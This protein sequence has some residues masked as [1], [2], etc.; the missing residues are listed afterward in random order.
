MKDFARRGAASVQASEASERFADAVAEVERAEEELAAWTRGEL[1]S[2]LG[3]DVFLA[4]FRERQRVLDETRQTL[5][6]IPKSKA[7]DIPLPDFDFEGLTPG[8]RQQLVRM[9]VERIEV[10][11]GRGDGRMRVEWRPLL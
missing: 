7:V 6:N 5:S 11:R 2:V 3:H 8:D 4:G 1:V 10:A 9:F